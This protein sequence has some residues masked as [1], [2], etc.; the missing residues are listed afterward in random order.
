MGVFFGGEVLVQVAA[1]DAAPDEVDCGGAGR[2]EGLGDDG[3]LGGEFWQRGRGA[4]VDA[5]GHAHGCGDAD[6]GG[7]TDDHV[8]DNCG[9]LLVV[10]C[11]YVGLFGREFGL[12]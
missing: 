5:D 10:G 8:A 2:G 11:E 9:Y 12:V 7:S 4:A 1:L 3:D 6:G